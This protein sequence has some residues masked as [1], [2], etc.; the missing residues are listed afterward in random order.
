MFISTYIYSKIL[1][2]MKPTQ[3]FPPPLVT[4]VYNTKLKAIIMCIVLIKVVERLA[5][6]GVFKMSKTITFHC[7]IVIIIRT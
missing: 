7:F 3:A 1:G 2:G 5:N 6:R 4:P